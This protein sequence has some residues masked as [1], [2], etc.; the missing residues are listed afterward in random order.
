MASS[1]PGILLA[2]F[3]GVIIDIVNRKLIIV[4][5]DIIRGILILALALVYHS[6]QVTIPV[7]YGATVLLSM[8]GVVF[9]PAISATIPNLVKKEEL[10]QAN[11]RDSFS[12]SATGILGPIVG[13]ALL[14]AAGYVSVFT[15]T[16]ISFILSGISEMFIRFPERE[17]RAPAAAASGGP[18]RQFVI[19]FREGFAY[20]W[21]NAGVRTIIMFALVLNFI[22]TPSFQWCSPT[23]ARRF[24]RWRPLTTA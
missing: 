13:A 17:R 20:I 19:D 9:G 23:S 8:C 5:A 12:M 24:S 22:G 10:V 16:G 18:A 7:L 14:G 4:G 11:A 6:G 3:A 2:P 21:S 15:I 1:L